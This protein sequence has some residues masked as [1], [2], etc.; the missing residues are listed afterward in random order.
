MAYG[1]LRGQNRTEQNGSGIDA[2]IKVP[3]RAER[4]RAGKRGRKGR[5]KRQVAQ[6]TKAGPGGDLGY[7]RIASE[8]H[9]LRGRSHRKPPLCVCVCVCV[10]V[11]RSSLMSEPSEPILHG[12]IEIV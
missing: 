2:Q 6:G 5:R 11:R 7:D 8:W 10:C 4:A 3:I 12:G 9:F 1:A